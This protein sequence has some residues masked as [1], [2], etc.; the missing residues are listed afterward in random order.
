VL[1]V[2]HGTNKVSAD[3]AVRTSLIECF[4]YDVALDGMVIDLMLG[5]ESRRDSAP[6][7]FAKHVGF[8]GRGQYECE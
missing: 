4:H 7:R 1:L 3:C 6:T 8:K 5:L 2:L